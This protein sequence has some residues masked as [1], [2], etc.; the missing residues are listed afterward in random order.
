MKPLVRNLLL[1]AGLLLLIPVL[2][3]ITGYVY[4]NQV[5]DLV[6]AELNKHLA[7]EI[8]VD[9]ISF[10]LLSSFPYAELRF[11]KVVVKEPAHFSSSG[12]VL[13]AEKVSLLLGINSIFSRPYKLRKIILENASLNLQTDKDGNPNYE[14]WKKT[15]DPE[16]GGVEFDLQE[17]VFINVDVLYYN[18]LKKQDVSFLISE[19]NLSG[20]FRDQNFVLQSFGDLKSAAVK[21]DGTTY[22]GGKDCSVDL[23]ISVDRAKGSFGFSK[24]TLKLAG[25]E[26]QIEGVVSD[27]KDG[28]ETDLA[29]SSPGADLPSLL[30]V[31][32]EKYIAATGEYNYSGNM[33]FSGTVKGLSGKTSTPHVEFRFRCSDVSLNPKGTSYHLTKVNTAGY[34]TNRKNKANPVTYLK[35]EKFRALLQGKPVKAEIEIENFSRPL[36]SITAS[37]EMALEPLSK[38]FLPKPLESL[39]G[40]MTVDAS[41]NG[42]AGEKSTYRSSGNIRF[43]NVSFRVKDQ[44]LAFTGFGALIHLRGNDVTVDSFSGKA[45]NSDF[46]LSG[47]FRNLFGWLL[48]EKQKLDISATASSSLIDLNEL[49]SDDNQSAGSKD[50]VFRLHFSDRLKCRLD[51]EADR[52]LFRKFEA[53]SISGQLALESKVLMT[54]QLNFTTSGG[55]VRLKG[56]IDDRPSDSLRIEYDALINGLNINSLFTEMGNFGQ[57]VI[58]DKNLKGKVSAEIQFRSMWSDRLD[59]NDKSI[60]VK[61]DIVIEN[62]ELLNFDPMLALSRF[63]KG[64]D[65]RAIRFS[66]LSNTIEIRDRKIYIPMMEIKSSAI[67]IMAS[68]VH[69]F[70]NAVDYK[71]QLYLSQIMG[72]KV[73][74]QNTEFGVIEDDGLGRPRLY[75]TMK[76]T[77]SDPKFAW[78]RKATEKKI[79]DEISKETKGLKQILKEEF[80]RKDPDQPAKEIKKPKQEELQID[81]EDDGE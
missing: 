81:F 17:V 51:L 61:S 72:R 73:K 1:A 29:I 31:I 22:L 23:G 9:H 57:E 70:D 42:I 38:F 6:V 8:A 76:G 67:D 28:L 78:D 25:L 68:G 2:L 77:A 52:L 14:V 80:G 59:I 44:P 19:G 35:L 7:T 15:N 50:S 24:S 4:R 30:S 79:T 43:S 48:D 65:L 66:T 20:N 74:E 75:L 41:F 12:T 39:S 40:T 46:K 21:L 32:P 13:S 36:L 26:L 60:Y 53:G 33:D 45:G 55:S 47:E 62:G 27:V 37:A 16:G 56:I 54:R 71:L 49:L 18:V 10:S 64:T 58:I 11:S 63:V 69:T 3:G 34:F 5:R